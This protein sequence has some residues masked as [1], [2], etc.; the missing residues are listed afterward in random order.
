VN[1]E[2]KSSSP[3]AASAVVEGIAI[4]KA[5][6]WAGDP[7]PRSSAGTVEEEHAR[8]AW[9]IRRATRGVEELVRL[10]PRTEAELFEPEV[11]ILGELGPVMLARVD[12]G[13]LAEDAV[14]EATAELPTDLMVDARA[15]L[16]DGLAHDSRTVE[17]L[18]EGREGDRVLVTA[19]LTPSVVASLPG[20]V[21]GIIAAASEGVEERGT[22]HTSHAA[23]L[24]RGRVIPFVLVSRDVISAIGNDDLLVLDAAASPAAIWVMPTDSIVEGAHARREAWTRTRSDEETQVTQPLVHLGLEVHVN[25]GSLHEH[26]PAS[27]EGIGLVRAELIFAHWARAPNELEQF[28]ALRAIAAAVGRAPVVVRLFDAGGDKPLPWL[29]APEGSADVRGMELL[30]MHPAVLATQLRSIA[31]LAESTD[32]RAL[33]PVV[34]CAGDVER[35]RALTRGKLPIGAMIETPEAVDRS[36]EI[37]A[38]SDF[39][40]IGTNDLFATVTGHGEPGSTL[41]L[42]TRVLC[43]IARVITAARGHARRVTV[44][45]EMAGEPHSARILVGLGVDAI[46]VAIGRF[47]KVKLSF[48]DVTIDDCRAVALEALK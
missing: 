28:G 1:T 15:R 29:R 20:R 18:L 8:L 5:V 22:G 14:N 35:I 30:F 47:A 3:E 25:V 45:G 21:V 2:T 6:V 12:A 17:S 34:T 48:R 33:L 32:V 19:K 41:S 27:A 39:I 31:R 26:V 46:S 16:L 9:A 4:G 44:C 10:L 13:V 40:C 37:A 36:E 38:V 7:A 42:D 43:M 23:I 11:A 24:A